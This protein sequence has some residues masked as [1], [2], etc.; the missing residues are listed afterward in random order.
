MMNKDFCGRKKL[1]R[2][3]GLTSVVEQSGLRD[4]VSLSRKDGLRFKV[5]ELTAGFS[6]KL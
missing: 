1:R 3:F 5:S 2:L 4:D 6:S